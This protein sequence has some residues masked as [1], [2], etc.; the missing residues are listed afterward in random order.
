MNIMNIRYV[1]EC[2]PT[3]YDTPSS[4]SI[5]S[6]PTFITFIRSYL[7][8]LKKGVRRVCQPYLVYQLPNS[9]GWCAASS[10]RKRCYKLIPVIPKSVTAISRGFP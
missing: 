7:Q 10:I 3:P 8:T 9:I 1:D 5:S 2:L 4:L 6:H